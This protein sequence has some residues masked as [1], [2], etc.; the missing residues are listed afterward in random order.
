MMATLLAGKLLQ[1]PEPRR[2]ADGRTIAIAT[3]RARVGKSSSELRRVQ[4]YE[5]ETQL[6]LLRLKAGGFVALQ[7]VPNART[8]NV[9]GRHAIQH[10]L[11]VEHVLPLRP[12]GESMLTFPEELERNWHRLPPIR[13][14]WLKRLKQLGVSVDAL[15]EPELP[16]QAK[17]VLHGDCFEFATGDPGEQASDALVLLARGDC[18]EPAD[19]VAWSPKS[20]RLASWSG[21]P[22]LGME[23]LGEPRM[24]PDGAVEVFDDPLNWLLAERDGLLVVSFANAAHLLREAAPLKVSSAAFG[25]RLANLINPKPPRILAPSAEVLAPA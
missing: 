7:G 6:A 9:G 5:R 21:I 2:T 15:C 23:C 12:E 8:A 14:A 20:D 24:D 4:A 11:Y 3:V 1:D 16:V 18:G 25:R 22:M 10:V 17:I 19:F 13:V